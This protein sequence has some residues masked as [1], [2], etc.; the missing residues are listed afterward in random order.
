MIIMQAGLS[1]LHLAAERNYLDIVRSFFIWVP[2]RRN[3]NGFEGCMYIELS[4]I[5]PQIK[6]I[7]PLKFHLKYHYTNPMNFWT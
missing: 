1:S 7:D 6:D 4:K 2:S 3:E 5:C